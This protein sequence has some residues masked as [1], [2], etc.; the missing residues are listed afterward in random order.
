M[1]NIIFIYINEFLYIVNILLWYTVSPKKTWIPICYHM[2]ITR[3][4]SGISRNSLDH[5]STIHSLARHI[6]AWKF[7]ARLCSSYLLVNSAIHKGDS[8]NGI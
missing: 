2:L 5:L 8:I 1:Y 4:V 6:K 3:F 7:E